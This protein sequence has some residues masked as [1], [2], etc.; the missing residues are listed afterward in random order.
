MS[1][2]DWKDKVEEFQ[3]VDVLILKINTIPYYT[4]LKTK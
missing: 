2:T 4:L 3:K 1:D